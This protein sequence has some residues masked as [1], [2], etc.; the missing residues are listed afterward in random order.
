MKSLVILITGLIGFFS[1]DLNAFRRSR[2]EG[3]APVRVEIELTDQKE[4]LKRTQRR[5]KNQKFKK[6]KNYVNRRF[7]YQD[8]RPK[9][10]RYGN[11]RTLR[12]MYRN[13]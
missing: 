11:Q 3:H 1:F 13:D 10:A 9:D 5:Y 7:K 6:R 12:R 2:R 4:K 8:T